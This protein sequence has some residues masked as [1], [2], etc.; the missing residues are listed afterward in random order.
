MAD[1]LDILASLVAVGTPC[2]PE[3]GQE[4]FDMEQIIESILK[5]AGVMSEKYPYEYQQQ[6]FRRVVRAILEHKGE[7]VTGLWSRQSGKT[8]CIGNIVASCMVILPELAKQFPDDWRLNI[9]DELGRYRGY[10]TGINFGIYAPILDQS[11]IMFDRIRLVLDSDGSKSVLAELGISYT[12]NRGNVVTLSNGS[13]ALAMSASKT[14]KIEGHTHHIVIAEEAQDI[15]SQKMR[16]SIH[17]M[18]ASCI[19]GDAR[20]ALASGEV[21]CLRDRK[22]LESAHTGCF[23]P[24]LKFQK[25]RPVE[26]VDSGKQNC[27]TVTLS[28]GKSITGTYNHPVI[29]KPRE[30]PRLPKW[31]SLENIKVGNQVAVPRSIPFFGKKSIGVDSARVLGLMVGDGSYCHNG[32]PNF[33]ND[34]LET[35]MFLRQWCRKAGAKLKTYCSH[36]TV[37]GRLFKTVGI[38]GSG[39]KGENPLINLLR[40]GNCFGQTKNAKRVP[41]SIW[42]APAKE[43]AAFLGGLFDADGCVMVTLNR[44]AQITLTQANRDILVEVGD[45]LI[46]FGIQS[47]I[48]K[49]VS[50]GKGFGKAGSAA[51]ILG[52]YDRDSILNFCA[53]I[54]FLTVRKQRR[55]DKARRILLKRRS[56]RV[57]S[58]IVGSGQH[59]Y[60]KPLDND[61]CWERVVSLEPAG[62]QQVY[63]LVMRDGHN[64]I[65]NNIVVHNTKGSIIKIGTASTHKGDF[66]HS[67]QYNRRLQAVKGIQNHYFFPYQ[68]CVKYNSLYRD[69]IKEEQ[70]RIG[71][72]SDEFRMSY[73]CEWLLERGMFVTDTFLMAKGVATTQGKYSHIHDIGYMGMN[74]VV[75]VDLGKETD[76]TV[77]TVM[78]VDWATPAVIQTIVR[79]YQETDFIAYNKHVIAWKEFHGDDYEFQYHELLEW[80]SHFKPIKKV[81]LDATREASFANR[82]AHSPVMRDVEVQDFIFN[83]QSKAA[84]YRLLHGDIL[85]RRLSFPA[86][87]EARQTHSYRKFLTQMLD[88]V[89]TYSGEYLVVSHP[90]EAGAHDDYPDSLMLANYGANE[91][92]Q[93]MAIETFT[94]NAFI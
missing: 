23:T 3:T 29:I 31:E 49:V 66:F 46:R 28:S 86:G 91:P 68:V 84:G 57:A 54:A 24:E 18:I 89:K 47:A 21:A 37:E 92:T 85:S 63:D 10:K 36:T 2:T 22:M 13:S 94:S 55:L 83:T 16:K 75:G 88:L 80:L 33:S 15:D 42:T 20:I 4:N 64:F 74:L 56:K 76:S 30:Y 14:S 82:L 17:P 25:Q 38:S 77:I 41:S 7:M 58:V 72:N 51:Y 48:R 26:W 73:S 44:R 59:R 78:D 53:N 69:Y 52:I 70:M 43:V 79:N 81:V 39:G 32:T 71:E 60:A 11:Q 65:A 8:E 87:D 34:D 1:A 50:S 67:I 12:A 62:K 61:L 93:D 5:L 90:E 6:F 45:L 35:F 9:T 40:A 27:L 19:T